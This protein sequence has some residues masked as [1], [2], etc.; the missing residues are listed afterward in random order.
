[1]RITALLLCLC[2]LSVFPQHAA[3]ALTSA[4]SHSDSYAR[5][6]YY[7][8]LAAVEPTG[9]LRADI[10]AVALSQ[11]GYHEG[12]HA[13]D[14]SGSSS[15]SG[16][17]TEYGR[18]FGLE[19]DSWC[20]TFVWWCAR[21]AG[22]QES[23]IHKTEWAKAH[24]QPFECLPFAQCGDIR[25]GDIAYVDTSG[26]DGREDHVGIVTAVTQSEVTLTEG[27][28]S[29]RV[30]SHTYSRADG[31]RLTGSGSAF[32]VKVG[33]PDY[34]GE[35]VSHDTYSTQLVYSPGAQAYSSPG[36]RKTGVLKNREYMLLSSDAS[37][38]WL[39]IV[40]DDGLGSWY[41][42][43][44]GASFVTRDLPPITGYN[45]WGEAGTTT[46]AP[47]P[48]Q[49]TPAPVQTTAAV[50]QTTAASV[51]SAPADTYSSAAAQTS[52]T[53]AATTTVSTMA[54]TAV[55]TTAS[56]GTTAAPTRPVTARQETAAEGAPDTQNGAGL[57]TG[58]VFGLAGIAGVVLSACAAGNAR[59][60]RKR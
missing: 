32:I 60:R 30:T 50:T 47:A 34:G 11:T 24:L 33:S 17:F 35:N 12:A 27:N 10:V 26:N 39:Q 40:A 48:V 57:P 56:T 44:Q 1:M 52:Q 55:Y 15:G 43:S 16:N 14:L 36:G 9:D 45:A 3:Q 20:A 28:S 53:S 29:N 4:F 8:R 37:A 51:Y 25:P 5:S 46:Y 41:I 49:T 21:Q 7:T 13:S 31:R 6:E 22:V 54:S 59:G 18:N 58:V 19:G 38:D 23:I 42:S 2:L